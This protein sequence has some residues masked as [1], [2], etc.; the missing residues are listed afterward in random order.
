MKCSDWQEQTHF[1][2]NYKQCRGEKKNTV[3]VLSGTVCTIDCVC[4]VC[5]H[6]AG[7]TEMCPPGMTIN[8][9]HGTWNS[10]TKQC[11]KSKKT[12]VDLNNGL[13]T[14]KHTNNKL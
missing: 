9:K 8:R 7:G 2:Q 3:C 10:K 6:R 1:Q 12:Q 13:P 11:V 14:S 5:W 4:T